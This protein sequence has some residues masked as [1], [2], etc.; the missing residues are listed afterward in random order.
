MLLIK[1]ANDSTWWSR[2]KSGAWLKAMFKT[3][4]SL[5]QKAH[6]EDNESY[7]ANLVTEKC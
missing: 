1:F 2:I 5:A 4:C 6:S 7:I 3:I